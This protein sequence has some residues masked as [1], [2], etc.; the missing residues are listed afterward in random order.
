VSESAVRLRTP[1]S[2]RSDCEHR[3]ALLYVPT[4]G[5]LPA[6]SYGSPSAGASGSPRAR[7]RDRAARTASAHRVMESE[8]QVS[9]RQSGGSAGGAARTA[10]ETARLGQQADLIRGLKQG[11]NPPTSNGAPIIPNGME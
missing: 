6:I 7:H 5:R 9:D 10:R 1:P 8:A 4:T 11:L 2:L 3:E